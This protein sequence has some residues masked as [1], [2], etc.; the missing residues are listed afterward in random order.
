MHWPTAK[1]S[2]HKTKNLFHF[3]ININICNIHTYICICIL[4]L[5]QAHFSMHIQKEL[6]NEKVKNIK[7][8][9]NCKESNLKLENYLI[10]FIY[11]P[12]VK[13]N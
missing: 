2:L 11:N 10:L 12:N 7:K 9:L 1:F 6:K 3:N 8:N 4:N 5:L 13:E